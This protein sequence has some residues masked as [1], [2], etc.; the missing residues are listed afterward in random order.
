M[1]GAIGG[2]R[3]S[4]TVLQEARQS[5]L[6]PFRIFRHADDSPVVVDAKHEEAAVAV[7][8][9]AERLADCGE[10]HRDRA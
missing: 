10:C 3:P 2:D 1:P 9:G 7:G 8:E 6:H 4:A 5:F